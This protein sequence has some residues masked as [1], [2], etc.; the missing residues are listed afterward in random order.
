MHNYVQ[1][2]EIADRIMLMQRGRMTYEKDAAA[3][4]VAE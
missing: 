1:M 3:T 2:L 4:S